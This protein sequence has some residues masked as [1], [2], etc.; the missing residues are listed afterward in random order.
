MNPQ[1]Q[2]RKTDIRLGRPVLGERIQGRPRRVAIPVAALK[3]TSWAR[4]P[5]NRVVV[6]GQGIAAL[7]A[8]HR[9]PPGVTEPAGRRTEARAGFVETPSPG[10]V[11]PLLLLPSQLYWPSMREPSSA[12]TGSGADLHTA[13]EAAVIVVAGDE[14]VEI[15]VAV[16]APPMGRRCKAG[17]VVDRRAVRRSLGVGDGQRGRLQVLARSRRETMAT[18]GSRNFFIFLFSRQ[19]F[20]FSDAPQFGA[21]DGVQLDRFLSTCAFLRSSIGL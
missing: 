16:E 6:V 12:R 10:K 8:E 7:N 1:C 20:R 4:R 14:A 15:V 17:P 11:T 5:S 2:N 19:S 3:V 21:V 13:E 9:P 18:V